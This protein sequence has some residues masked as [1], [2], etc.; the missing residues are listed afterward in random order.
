MIKELSKEELQ[1]QAMDWWKFSTSSVL[2]I[3]LIKQYFI[4]VWNKRGL[5]FD[6]YYLLDNNQILEIYTKEHLDKVQP[7]E[8]QNQ[9]DTWDDI[10]KKYFEENYG[11]GNITIWLKENYLPPIKK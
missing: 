6:E 2:K 7:Q 1:K 10:F 9:I 11:T 5:E 3:K 4:D 8:L